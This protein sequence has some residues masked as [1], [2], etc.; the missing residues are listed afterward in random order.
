MKLKDYEWVIYPFNDKDDPDKWD[1]GNHWS[2]LL[3]RK[4]GRKY[5]HFD[6]IKKGNEIHTRDLVAKLIDR[7]SFSKNV[8]CRE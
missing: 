3:Y 7:D 4:R 5:L 8:N 2:L 1:G 6:S